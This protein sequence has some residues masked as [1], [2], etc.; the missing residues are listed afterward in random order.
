[1]NF[2]DAHVAQLELPLMLARKTTE[3]ASEAL[4]ATAA[5]SSAS[6]GAT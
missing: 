5:E 1:M 3:S 6:C 4:A 2:C